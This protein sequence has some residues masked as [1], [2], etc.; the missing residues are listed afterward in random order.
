MAIKHNV[1]C[2][3]VTPIYVR[4]EQG[5][6]WVEM[7]PPTVRDILVAS[8]DLSENNLR[9]LGRVILAMTLGLF[10]YTAAQ[11]ETWTR[12]ERCRIIDALPLPAICE[13]A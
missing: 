2:D 7:V 8:R 1:S 11:I 6:L 9:D 3:E 13:A 4:D 5:E 10:P 12:E